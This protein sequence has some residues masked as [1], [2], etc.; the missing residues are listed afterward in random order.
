M[1]SPALV[2]AGPAHAAVLATLHAA[3]FD[4]A[5]DEAAFAGLLATPGTRALI[6]IADGGAP[7]SVLG[8]GGP[9]LGF[10]MIRQAADEVEILTIGVLPAA[11]RGGVAAL[12]LGGGLADARHAGAATAFLEVAVDNAAA[13]AFYTAQGFTEVGR[14]ARYYERAAGRVDALILSRPI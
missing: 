12:L 2:A 4:D 14:R 13:R 8:G 11:R 10:V 1:R 3:C 6:A 9:P 7:I 5:W